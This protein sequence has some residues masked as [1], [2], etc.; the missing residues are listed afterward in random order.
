MKKK[1]LFLAVSALF[2]LAPMLTTNT[3]PNQI[4]EIDNA[5]LAEFPAL[6][7]GS[8][9]RRGME[10]YVEGRIGFRTEMITTYQIFRDRVFKKLVHPNYLGGKNG[11]VMGKD[12]ITYQHLDVSQ[13][14]V[15]NF[16]DYVRSL[17]DFCQGRNVEFLFYL[18]PNKETIY[19]EYFPD[20]YNIKDQPNRTD[21]I[22]ERLDE[23]GVAHLD[24]RELFFSLKDEE[25]LYN[26]KYDALHWNR[27]GEFFGHQQ[28][29]HYLNGKFP[30][31]GEL[32]QDE[33]E[34]TQVLQPYLTNS[35]FRIDEM[36][37]EY[38]LINTAAVQNSEIFNQIVVTN[39]KKYYVC[40][41]NET[42]LELG[43]PTVL[44]FG[45][46]YFGGRTECYLNHCGE[47]VMLHTTNMPNAE[48]YISVFQ[49]D[50]VIYEVVERELGSSWD[51]FKKEKRC[52]DLNTALHGGTITAEQIFL[53]VDLTALQAEATNCE[54]VSFSGKLDETA[55]V[56]SSDVLALKALLNG[57]EY[58]S[59]FDRNTL[60]Y[61]F[62]FRAE[63]IT[64]A[65]EI[66]FYIL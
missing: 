62:S 38:N 40:Y 32:D 4:S 29:I 20:G 52:Y 23:K 65:S 9:V 66:L 3:K 31:M 27:T 5:Y 11:H 33:F 36:V 6:Q 28:I 49:P 18:C 22:L 2:L 35:R 26:V 30:E 7:L 54:I 55:V 25:Q 58:D 14:Y 43:A 48:Y 37:P 56:V 15:E 8:G 63:D 59:I 39:P 34:V 44:I 57:K 13:E 47:V 12:L 19:P 50:I 60:S 42:A 24:P 1:I 61:N 41:Q 16:T 46:S 51:N 64:A 53:D 17:N 45:D 21:R 10:K